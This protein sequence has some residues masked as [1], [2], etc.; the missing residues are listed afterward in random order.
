[1]V[2]VVRV[3]AAVPGVRVAAVPGVRAAAVPDVRAAVV[4]AVLVAAVLVGR[5]AVGRGVELPSGRLRHDLP[6]AR[7][8][9]LNCLPI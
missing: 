3:A 1:V 9:R 7:V 2:A 5:V 8:V 6:C 4:A